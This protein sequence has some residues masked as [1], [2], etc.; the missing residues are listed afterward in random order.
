VG[1][2]RRSW[3]RR[4]DESGIPLLAVRLVLGGLFIWMGVN[5]IGHPVDFLK[6]IREYH[7]LPESPA[8]FL[9]AT[10]IVLPWLEVVAGTAL[11]L[12]VFVRG[13]AAVFAIMLAVF[14]PAI[15]FRA[16]EIRAQT[17]T[18][19]FDIEFDCGCGAGVVVTWKK[20][21]ENTG[22]LLL[23]LYG[24]FSLS[25]RFCLEHWWDRRKPASTLCRRCGC[26]V[27]DLSDGLC[28]ACREKVSTTPLATPDTA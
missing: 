1:N 17:G 6:E 19:F 7:A 21:L 12:G 16:L 18:P 15:L 27:G 5:K 28:T 9:N 3:I 20:L 8:I 13:A 26:A 2:E 10:A 14:T 25:R 22:L 11:V 4:F 23:A 24:V